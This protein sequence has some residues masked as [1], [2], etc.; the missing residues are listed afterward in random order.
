MEPEEYRG[1]DSWGV[2]VVCTGNFARIYSKYVCSLYEAMAFIPKDKKDD[3]VF[4]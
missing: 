1:G 3:V 2:F 4:R